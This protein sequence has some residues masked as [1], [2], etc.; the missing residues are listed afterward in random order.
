MPAPA[1]PDET[2]TA[3]AEVVTL[4]LKVALPR[5]EPIRRRATAADVLGRGAGGCRSAGG[6]C[7]EAS[8]ACARRVQY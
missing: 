6:S 3:T 7:F 1:D 8:V 4:S 5:A 2:G